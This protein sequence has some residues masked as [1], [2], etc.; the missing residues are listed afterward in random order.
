MQLGRAGPCFSA[1]EGTKQPLSSW[2]QGWAC[3]EGSQAQWSDSQNQS[4][5]AMDSWRWSVLVCTILVQKDKHPVT[6]GVL[7]R[8][9]T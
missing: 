2:F 3:R 4:L 6:A 1:A 7:I 9:T 8:T 5:N